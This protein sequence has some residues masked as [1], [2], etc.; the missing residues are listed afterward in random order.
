MRM[1]RSGKLTDDI[2]P[3]RVIKS[4]GLTDDELDILLDDLFKDEILDTDD[5]LE[6]IQDAIIEAEFWESLEEL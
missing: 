5:S 6:A 2:L 1:K 4:D 3:L